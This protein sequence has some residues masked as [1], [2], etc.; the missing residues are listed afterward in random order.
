MAVSHPKDLS[1]HFEKL[2]INN[3]AV[4]REKKDG[5]FKCKYC[6]REFTNPQALG[7]HQNAHRAE[8][9]R[10]KEK[11]FPLY[12]L[13]T[14]SRARAPKH[15]H[16]Y[17]GPAFGSSRGFGRLG[18]GVQPTSMIRKPSSHAGFGQVAHH[19]NAWRSAAAYQLFPT[20]HQ[21][22]AFQSFGPRSSYWQNPEAAQTEELDLDLR[23]GL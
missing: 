8:R 21:Q 10:E 9:E 23:L 5:V 16:Y 14:S 4:K 18:L 17:Q 20:N 15:E 19:R 12:R 7:G 1:A 3:S 2:I 11:L 13:G 6:E 22:E